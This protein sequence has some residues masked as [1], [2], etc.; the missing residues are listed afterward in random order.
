MIDPHMMTVAHV[1]SIVGLE[2]I[3]VNNAV[4]CYFS[5]DDRQQSL[6]PYVWD[7]G[8]ENLPAPPKQAEHGHFSGCS[9]TSLS[10]ASSSE[11]TF[12]RF[13][14]PT[15]LVTGKLARNET[16]KAHEKTSGGAAMDAHDF[17]GRPG[18]RSGNKHPQQIHLL[19]R[20]ESTSSCIHFIILFT[21]L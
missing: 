5:L 17:R 2:R 7:N 11:V 18:S 21:T 1:E 9:S 12:I 16:T 15:Q 19:A 6:R 13:G 20:A 3:G 10:F 4:W 8:S 14:F